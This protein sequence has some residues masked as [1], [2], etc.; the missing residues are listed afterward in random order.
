MR[1]GKIGGRPLRRVIGMRVIEAGDLKAAAARF[2]RNLDQLRRSNFIA[3][4]RR[5]RARVRCAYNGFDLP[6]RRSGLTQQ[7][8]ATLARVGLFA[9]SAEI[10][11]N[12]AR[13]AQK[14][15]SCFCVAVRAET[16][17]WELCSV[18]RQIARAARVCEIGK[19]ANIRC[20]YHFSRLERPHETKIRTS[21]L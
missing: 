14:R 13:Q 1:L 20:L 8:P 5:I 17:D 16:P 9:V 4:V 2:L 12:R 3:V 7:C 19:R 21:L 10:L 11:Q 6:A 18:M 15:R